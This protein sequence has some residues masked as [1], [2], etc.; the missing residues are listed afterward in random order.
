M[1]LSEL[2]RM[3]NNNSATARLN[4]IYYQSFYSHFTVIFVRFHADNIMVFEIII[5]R[6]FASNWEEIFSK[7]LI[8]S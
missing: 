8:L 3:Y 4:S 5:K 2:T 1:L 6:K 7:M